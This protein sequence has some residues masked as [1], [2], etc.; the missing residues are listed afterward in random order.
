VAYRD[1]E[2]KFFVHE[3]KVTVKAPEDGGEMRALPFQGAQKLGVRENIAS[4]IYLSGG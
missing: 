4:M 1:A 2:W 3:D